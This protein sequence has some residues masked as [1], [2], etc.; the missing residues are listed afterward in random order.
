ML[1]EKARR[2][3][4]KGSGIDDSAR[5]DTIARLL[6]EN[7]SLKPTTA[8][9]SIG[10]SDPS[11]IRR[12]RDKFN[13]FNVTQSKVMAETAVGA[14]ENR[15][16]GAQDSA[17]PTREPRKEASRQVLAAGPTAARKVERARHAMPTATAAA[18]INREGSATTT[19]VITEMTAA[20]A[21][22]SKPPGQGN[23]TSSA[24]G[25]P[26]A[27][28]RNVRPPT[29][30]TEWLL[31]WSG[32]GVSLMSTA[33]EAQLAL[34]AF[35]LRSPPVTAALRGQLAWCAL[36]TTLTGPKPKAR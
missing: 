28:A 21:R 36:A 14:I 35:L 12:L 17:S 3:R 1:E 34:G 2:G 26:T 16:A 27:A 13:E 15:L 22:A 19:A 25:Q 10:I 33:V 7:P 29:D 24:A 6:A 31:L 11:A 9:K 20:P 23:P 32:L 4:P 8:I 18:R 5:L 30:P